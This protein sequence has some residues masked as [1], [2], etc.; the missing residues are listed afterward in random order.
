MEVP[1]IKLH[2]SVSV[3]PIPCFLNYSWLAKHNLSM[4]SFILVIESK[5]VRARPE[6]VQLPLLTCGN[7]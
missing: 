7:D 2:L 4:H 3:S 5:T 6:I 1:L